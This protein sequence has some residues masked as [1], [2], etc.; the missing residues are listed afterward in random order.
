MYD[1]EVELKIKELPE[2]LR[3]KVLDYIELLLE[4]HEKK[5]KRQA[6]FRFDW[7]GE[8]SELREKFSSVELQHKALGWR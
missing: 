4:K 8:L 1:R 2:N 3:K 6:K 5:E 7:E